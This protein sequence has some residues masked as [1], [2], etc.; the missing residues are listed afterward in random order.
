MSLSFPIC[1]MR[2]MTPTHPPTLREDTTDLGLQQPCWR[3]ATCPRL[4]SSPRFGSQQTHSLSRPPCCAYPA[5]GTPLCLFCNIHPVPP[6]SCHQE[7]PTM[8][9]N[10]SDPARC[11]CA[12][13]CKAL[14]RECGPCAQAL[15]PSAVQTTRAGLWPPGSVMLDPGRGLAGPAGRG[16]GAHSLQASGPLI[17]PH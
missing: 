4:Q 3:A 14:Q 15:T 17:T 12:W 13:L 8:K 10:L 9:H 5:D 1:R 2:R 7:K 16:Q 11:S 6:H